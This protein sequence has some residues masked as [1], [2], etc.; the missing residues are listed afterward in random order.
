[1][2]EFDGLVPG[3]T[4]VLIGDAAFGIRAR[5]CG[6]EV[7][8]SFFVPGRGLFW[9]LRVP[10][11]RATVAHQVAD[12]G[13]GGIWIDGCRIGSS[14]SVPGGVSRTSGSAFNCAV[15][16]SFRRETGAESGHNPNVG[17]WPPNVALVHEATCRLVGTRKVRGGFATNGGTSDTMGYHGGWAV[18]EGGGYIG[19]DGLEEVAAWE[20][21][22]SCF[23]SHVDRDGDGAGAS[24]FY[25]Q[26]EG[27]AQLAAWFQKLLTGRS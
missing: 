11:T 14:K 15:D 26:F 4:L 18:R 16:G 3:T 8:D 24:R 27:D 6:I 17:R 12:T 25:P 13:A 23:V 19:S 20:C 7:R 22:P 1:M 21:S 5:R 9:L 2:T 10:V